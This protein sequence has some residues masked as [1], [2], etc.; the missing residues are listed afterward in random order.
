[1]ISTE[2]KQ[3]I[4]A[5]VR[6]QRSLFSGTDAQYATMLGISAAQYSRIQKGDLERVISERSWMNLAYRYDVSETAAAEWLTVRT[7]VLEFISSQLEDCQTKSLCGIL[8][9]EVG[10]GKSYAAKYYSRTHANVAY[11]DCSTCKTCRKFLARLAQ[12]LGIRKEGTF[13]DL[14]NDIVW[15]IKTQADRPLVILDEFG[16]LAREAVMEVKALWNATEYR[17]GWYAMGATALQQKIGN[18]IAQRIV[19]WSEVF[20]RLGHKYQRITPEVGKEMDEFMLSQAY[21]IADANMRSAGEQVSSR[22][23][24]RLVGESGNNL[25]RIHQAIIAKRRVAA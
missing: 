20:D 22:E 1:M 23:V 19:G 3:K 6:E 16:D 11:I 10:I 4:I 8:S 17:C 7:P 14:F 5:K 18:C 25:R 2:F 21:Q 13:Q 12:E 24:L 15:H 9:D